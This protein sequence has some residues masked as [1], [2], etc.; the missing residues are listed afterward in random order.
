MTELLHDIVIP[1]LAL[2]LIF[3]AAAWALGEGL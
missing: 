2:T 1:L 3:G